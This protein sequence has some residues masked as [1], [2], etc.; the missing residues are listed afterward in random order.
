[1]LWVLM[2]IWCFV[3]HELVTSLFT[4]EFQYPVLKRLLDSAEKALRKVLEDVAREKEADAR[5]RA[6]VA[7]QANR[8]AEILRKLE[9]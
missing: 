5:A 2:D 6:T 4:S 7:D 9:E 1:M 3:S 8:R